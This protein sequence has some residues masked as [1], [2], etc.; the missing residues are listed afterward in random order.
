MLGTKLRRVT[1]TTKLLRR[2]SHTAAKTLSGQ[3]NWQIF[4]ICYVFPKGYVQEK[5]AIKSRIEK[6]KKILTT[7]TKL[8]GSDKNGGN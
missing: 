2:K 1:P 7:I 4:L 8:V 6:K 3:R 5:V